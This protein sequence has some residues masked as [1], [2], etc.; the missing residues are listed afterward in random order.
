[1]PLHY[2][3]LFIGQIHWHFDEMSST[4]LYLA[5]LMRSQKLVE[6]T[7]VTTEY[8]GDGR[9]QIG[10]YWHSEKSKNLL[11]SIYLT[12]HFL[13]ATDHFLLSIAISLGMHDYLDSLPLTKVRI[14]WPNDLYV[15]DKKVCGIL[16]QNQISGQNLSNSIIGIGLN[17]NQLIFPKQLPNPTSL[18]LQLNKELDLNKLRLKLWGHI[19]KRYLQLRSGRKKELILDYHTHLFRKDELHSYFSQEHGAFEG[20]I[21]SVGESGQLRV[22]TN[23]GIQVF[24]F[25]EIEYIL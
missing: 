17:V 10:R 11:C 16:I 13:K 12:P 18:K 23:K 15:G 24:D 14:K 2:V 8:Q 19:E 4:N 3:S 6:G 9:G 7:V 21:I 5:D 25:R 22:Q 20:K 1:M